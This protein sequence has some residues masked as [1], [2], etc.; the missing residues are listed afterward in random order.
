MK[1]AVIGAGWGGMAAAVHAAQAGHRVTVL[2]AARTLGGRARTV[3]AM[4]EDG[5]QVLLDN[6]QHI[7]IGAYTACLGLMR[8]VGVDPDAALLRLPLALRFPDGSG[9]ALPDAAPPWDALAGIARARGWSAG[10]RLALLGRAARWRLAGFS[11][12]PGHTV[13]DLC[14][15]LPE[16]LVREF[17]DPLC[18]SAL[19]TPAQQACGQTFLRVVQDSLFAGRGGSHLLLPRTDL[20][21]LLPEP[22]AAWLRA[23]GHAV[24]T[25]RRVQAL[26]RGAPGQGWLVDGEPFGAV[27]LA[28]SSTEAARLVGDAS[29]LAHEHAALLSWATLARQLPFGAIATVYARQ[30]GHAGPLL[31]SPML[32]LR[33]GPQQPAQFVFD[34]GQLGGPEGLLAFVVSAFGGE[35]A[36]LE[37]AV[38]RQA[39]QE[40]AL[41]GLRLLQTVVERR[42]TFVCTPGLARP[43]LHIAQGLMACGDYVAGPYPATLEGAALHAAAAVAA[44]A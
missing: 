16:R 15:G 17:I 11:C 10:E 42:A 14:A 29:A 6:G 36:A 22:A 25:G 38:L 37:A 31:R 40:V 35:R 24:H 12:A 18:V 27:L 1:V 30:P 20:G 39:A 21:A 8:T 43:P 7:L 34:R 32:A 19:N 9:I 2:E 44:L 28:T 4:L 26:G 41:P 23:R 13:A 5:S 3:P 33:G